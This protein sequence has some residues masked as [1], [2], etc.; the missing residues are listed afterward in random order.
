MLFE[1][2]HL[3]TGHSPHVDGVRVLLQ[4]YSGERDVFLNL[5]KKSYVF[6]SK[7]IVF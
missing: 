7:I 4:G 3:V 1:A 2:G 6:L 5:I